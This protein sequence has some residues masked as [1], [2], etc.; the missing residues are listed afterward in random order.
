MEEARTRYAGVIHMV[1]AANGAEKF[2]TLSNNEARKES[3]EEARVVDNRTIE[4]WLGHPHLAVVGN[5]NRDGTQRSF[6]EKIRISV[7]EIFRILGFPIPLEIEDRYELE[8]FDPK[9]LPVSV[10][11]ISVDQTYLVS[12]TDGASERVGRRSWLDSSSYFHTVKR[13]GP[14]GGRVEIERLISEKEYLALLRY[15]DTTRRTI[16]KTRYC[17]VSGEQ[18]FEVD[19]FAGVHE[20]LIILERERTDKNDTTEIPPFIKVKRNVTN[21]ESLSNWALARPL[22]TVFG[23]RTLGCGLLF[24]C[25]CVKIVEEQPSLNPPQ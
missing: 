17:F 6:E 11:A 3:L 15:S 20:G 4:A 24:Y 23:V 12:K 19:V 21:D 22:I 10:E 2:Y 14:D 25:F 7:A 5:L 8:N 16:R 18:Y 13:P 1:T 9:L